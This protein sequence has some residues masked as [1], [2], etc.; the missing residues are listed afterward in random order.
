M[1][2]NSANF[3]VFLLITL[4]LYWA[5]PSL[6]VRRAVLLLASLLFY[7][8]WDYRFLALLGYVTVVAYVAAR[9][10]YA[11]PAQGRRIVG[12][13]LLLQLGQLAVFK[14]TNFFLASFGD[15]AHLFGSKLQP[16]PLEILLAIC[17]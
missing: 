16:P 12:L 13:T 5:V 10:V 9:L 14:Y 1:L 2:F 3:V 6:F 11:F 7:A 8:W 17:L 4:A 15:V